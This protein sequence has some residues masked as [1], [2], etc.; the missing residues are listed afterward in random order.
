MI[1]ADKKSFLILS[2]PRHPRSIVLKFLFAFLLGLG[3]SGVAF[4][5]DS[6]RQNLNTSAFYFAPAPYNSFLNQEYSS[7]QDMSNNYPSTI[8]HTGFKPYISA[9]PN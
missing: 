4:A 9:D 5:Q 3:F 6:A 8:I 2:N 1:I 7:Y